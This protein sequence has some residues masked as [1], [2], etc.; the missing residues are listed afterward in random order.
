MTASADPNH[1]TAAAPRHPEAADPHHPATD[2][3]HAEATA[4]SRNGAPGDARRDTGAARPVSIRYSLLVLLLMALTLTAISGIAF[5]ISDRGSATGLRDSLFDFFSVD[6]EARLPSWYGSVLWF[7]AAILT[8]M[9]MFSAV[10]R[11]TSW[12]LFTLICLYFSLDE[13][14]VVHEKINGPGTELAASMG[15]ETEFGWVFLAALPALLIVGVLLRHVW[16]LPKLQRYMIIA[17][18]T[19]FLAGA[20][21][22]EILGGDVWNE[23]N[24]T[25]EY[26]RFAL[27]EEFLEMAGVSLLIAALLSLVWVNRQDGTII[28]APEG[29][30]R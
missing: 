12:A 15:I 13:S 25:W 2:S 17:A 16:Q 19:V 11:R 14:A 27:A 22:F 29:T 28:P 30:P 1:T 24:Y 10:R 18:G 9:M 26:Y 21:G 20:A 7:T 5:E 8:L 3:N 6:Q 4:S 23:F